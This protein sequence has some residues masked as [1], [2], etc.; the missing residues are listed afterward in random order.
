[1][2][3]YFKNQG[4]RLGVLGPDN[5]TILSKYSIYFMQNN[6]LISSTVLLNQIYHVNS[7]VSVWN[8]MFS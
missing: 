4:T 6:I 8:L 7:G 2:K 1:M 5:G 3:I